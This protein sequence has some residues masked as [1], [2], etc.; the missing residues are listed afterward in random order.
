MPVPENVER[1][2]I[3]VNQWVQQASSQIE[4]QQQQKELKA[5]RVLF[6]DI[7]SDIV[8]KLEFLNRQRDILK[9][10]LTDYGQLG[11][12]IYVLRATQRIL[13]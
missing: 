1:F 12:K 3:N 5:P 8:S 6:D 4:G 13:L 9:G 11:T 7:E 10:I 2:L